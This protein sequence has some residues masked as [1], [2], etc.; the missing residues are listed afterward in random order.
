MFFI[1]RVRIFVDPPASSGSEVAEDVNRVDAE[2][3]RSDGGFENE[4]RAR[5]GNRESRGKS[6]DGV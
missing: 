6:R 1:E 3:I 4:V 2:K 5:I